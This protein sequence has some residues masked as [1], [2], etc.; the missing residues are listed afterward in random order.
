[1]ANILVL[2]DVIDAGVLIKRILERK[3]HSV[4]AFTE[5]EEA[6]AHA[7]GNEVDLAILDIKLRRMTGVE[8]LEELKKIRPALKAIMLTGYPT[9]ETARESMKLG[10][11]EYCVK[12]ID[13]DELESKVSD[14]LRG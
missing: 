13:K 9:L 10:A 1:M 5:E 12:P 8:V 6:L 4:T 2:D 11:N 14:V 7:R 3:G